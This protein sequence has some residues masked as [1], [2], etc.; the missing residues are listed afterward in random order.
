MWLCA[1]IP[2]KKGVCSTNSIKPNNRILIE[3]SLVCKA[4]QKNDVLGKVYQ[5]LKNPPYTFGSSTTTLFCDYQWI[6][7]IWNHTLKI[8]NSSISIIIYLQKYFWRWEHHVTVHVYTQEEGWYTWKWI[9]VFA[10][11]TIYLWSFP[12]NTIWWLSEN[13]LYNET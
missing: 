9:S 8:Y 4:R 7:C 5:V 13:S 6:V 2:R 11:S 10:E 3:N 12:D 1:C